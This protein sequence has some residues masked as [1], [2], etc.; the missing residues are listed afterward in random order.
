MINLKLDKKN[1]ASKLTTVLLVLVSILCVYVVIQVLTQGYVNFFGFS[2]FRVVTGSMEPTIAPGA[3]LI[4][5]DMPIEQIQVGDI[6]CFRSREA[7]MLGKSIT[8]RVI[9]IYESGTQLCLETKGDANTV[10]DALPVMQS[11]LIGKVIVYTGQKNVLAD[12]MSFLTSGMGF[13]ICIVMP[14]LLICGM[15]LREC[16]SNIQ[17]ELSGVM[18]DMIQEGQEKSESPQLSKEDYERIY[19]EVLQEVLSQK[20]TDEHAQE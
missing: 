11:N 14:C 17:K 15:I 9:S 4:S 20:A 5:K 7:N 19:Q 12:I 16:V 10:A 13:M 8:H 18:D 6:I 3:L 1:I 2:V